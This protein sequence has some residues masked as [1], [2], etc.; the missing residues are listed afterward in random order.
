MTRNTKNHVTNGIICLM[1]AYV[2]LLPNFY[3]IYYQVNRFVLQWSPTSHAAILTEDN[4][5]FFW[6]ANS[7]GQLGLND[8][9]DRDQPTYNTMLETL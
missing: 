5:C 2:A 4:H 1:I 8:T 9:E 3:G 7:H 6:G